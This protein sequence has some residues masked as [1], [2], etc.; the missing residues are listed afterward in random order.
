MVDAL[1]V[2][3]RKA[4]G[5]LDGVGIGRCL[6][7]RADQVID[8]VERELSQTVINA[9]IACLLFLVRRPPLRRSEW[10]VARWPLQRGAIER[11]VMDESAELLFVCAIS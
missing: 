5:R 11:L 2:R 6:E 7:R 3:E 9:A 1:A 4:P 10:I 8:D